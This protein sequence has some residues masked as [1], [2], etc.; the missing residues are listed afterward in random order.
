MQETQNSNERPISAPIDAA[1]DE[2]RLV[3]ETG[4]TARIAH[5][6]DPILAQLGFRLVRVR[7]LQQNGQ[8]LQIMAER[9]DGTITI[10]DCEEISQALSPE[11]DVADAITNEYRL[12][13]SSPGVD[14]PL[15][16]VSDFARAIDHE[17]R[18]ELT[19]P[20][21]NGRK[22]FR[23]LIKAIEGQGHQALLTL[24]RTDARSDE[25]KCVVVPLRDLDEAKLMLTDALI[26]QSLRAG[27]IQQATQEDLPAKEDERP[28]R[29]PGR[30]R[31][32]AGGKSKPLTPAGV[33]TK[34]KKG[35]APLKP[36]VPNP[37]G[38]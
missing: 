17:V 15:V 13:I 25:E 24:E 10:E 31:G 37:E 11:L 36:R 3:T 8:I 4:V 9:A 30:F 35:G 1:L 23:G 22:R 14:R 18:L 34:F 7:L 20:I 12:E 5:L 27:K 29:G 33:Q 28:R 32:A 2:P 16:R 6:A 38:E 21:E 19:L 26:R